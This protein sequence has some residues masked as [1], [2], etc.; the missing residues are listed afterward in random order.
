MK[1]SFISLDSFYRLKY[2]W[3]KNMTMF[4]YL[5]NMKFVWN[6]GKTDF[7]SRQGETFYGKGGLRSVDKDAC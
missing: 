3:I 4:I 2:F 1:A 6:C 5:V 7:S